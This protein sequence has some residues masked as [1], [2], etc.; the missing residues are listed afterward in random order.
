MILPIFQKVLPWICPVVL[1]VI[2][3]LVYY[4]VEI[5]VY[6]AVEF[7]VYFTAFIAAK[8][9]AKLT[10]RDFCGSLSNLQIHSDTFAMEFLLKKLIK[11]ID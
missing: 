1:S 11:T 8:I 10:V 3:I 2:E 7:I 6:F 4:A 5:I 9:H